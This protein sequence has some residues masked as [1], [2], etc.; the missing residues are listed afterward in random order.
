MY[1]VLIP[2]FEHIRDKEEYENIV[3]KQC[4]IYTIMTSNFNKLP[5]DLIRM[6]AGFLR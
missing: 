3:I 2:Y 1:R 5:V 4:P 6:T